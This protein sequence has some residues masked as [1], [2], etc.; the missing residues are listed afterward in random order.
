MNNS[1]IEVRP[2]GFVVM[3]I[4][5]L[6]AT[7]HTSA[8]S[9]VD[10]TND[11]E[12]L[13]CYDTA[14]LCQ[15]EE[16]DRDRLACFDGASELR[17]PNSNSTATS[18]AEPVSRKAA[19]VIPPEVVFQKVVPQEIVSQKEVLVVKESADKRVDTPVLPAKADRP[20]IDETKFGLPDRRQGEAARFIE[21]TIVRVQTNAN[22]VDYLKLDNGQIWR[23][24]ED[25]NMRFKVGQKVKIESGLLSSYKLKVI[26]KKLSVKVKR[27]K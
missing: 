3:V 25:S 23:E 6:L 5:L 13:A 20:Q 26:G 17:S 24:V 16:N 15:V 22:R 2:F 14:V 12:R 21:A 10:I 1:A 4:S 7:E 8:F 9:C 11:K 18:G 27:T 19:S